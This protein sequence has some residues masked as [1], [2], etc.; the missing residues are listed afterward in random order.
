ME[1]INEEIL[2]EISGG[3]NEISTFDYTIVYGDTLFEIAQRFNTTVQVLCKLNNIVNPDK[4]KAGD[5]I[6]IPQSKKPGWI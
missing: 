6:K 1:N 4:I 2:G 5:K 3:A